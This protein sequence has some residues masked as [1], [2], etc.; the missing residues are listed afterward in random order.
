M[1]HGHRIINRLV[2]MIQLRYLKYGFDHVSTPLIFKKELWEKSGHW[3]NYKEDMFAVT[4]AAALKNCNYSHNHKDP[5]SGLKPMNC[6][7]HCLMF[8]SQLHS[9]KDLPIRYA[10]FS[11]L[12][13]NEASAR[14]FHQDDG[15][16][17]CTLDQVQNEILSSFKFV[18]EVYTI[19]GF[20]KYELNLSTR[21]KENYIGNIDEW[22]KAEAALCKALDD[23]GHPWKINEG[24]G[25]FYGPQIDVHVQDALGRNHQTATVQLDFQLP[26][27]FSLKYLEESG[28]HGMPVMIHRA[29][30]GSI[31]RMLAVLTEHWARKWP[32]WCNPRQAIVTPIG[33]SNPEIISYVQKVAKYLKSPLSNPI[34]AFSENAETSAYLP[35]TADRFYVDLDLSTQSLNRSIRASQLNRYSFSLVADEKEMSTNTLS[36]R[37]RDGKQLGSMSVSEVA[38]MFINMQKNYQ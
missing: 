22:D 28:R 18:H 26:L 20:P 8:A 7:G 36:V 6:P 15:H 32:F 3:K 13:R 4:D 30:L 9:Y 35:S 2:D 34:A 37:Q 19:F 11:P 33:A 38:N 25:A 10:E 31:E 17:F 16:I 12:H 1:P 27:R 24:D 29:V 21:P 14:Q 5:D 23:N